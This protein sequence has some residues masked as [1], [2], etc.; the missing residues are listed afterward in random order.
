[1]PSNRQKSFRNF[2]WSFMAYSWIFLTKIENKLFSVVNI[3]K[4]SCHQVV[5]SFWRCEG[6]T[7]YKRI[8][9]CSFPLKNCSETVESMHILLTSVPHRSKVLWTYVQA[10]SART[11]LPPNAVRPYT[12]WTYVHSTLCR[13]TIKIRWKWQKKRPRSTDGAALPLPYHGSRRAALAHVYI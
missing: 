9:A 13:T 11:S 6:A 2:F 7:F 12:L 5:V 3:S 1:M 4:T 10:P 8:Q